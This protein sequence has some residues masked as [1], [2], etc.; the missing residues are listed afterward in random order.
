MYS[1]VAQIHTIF[2]DRYSPI[3]LIKKTP[4]CAS[5]F[6]PEDTLLQGKGLQVIMQECIIMLETIISILT[7]F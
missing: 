6:T 3:E 5:T 2:T 4:F 7:T 1:K